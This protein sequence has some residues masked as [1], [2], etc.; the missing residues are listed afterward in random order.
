MQNI[1]VESLYLP[2]VESITQRIGIAEDAIVQVET[3]PSN[4]LN[5]VGCE[6]AVL[7]LRMICE[8]ILLGST[9]AHLHEAGI[10]ISDS[11]WRPKDAFFELS[12][13]SEHPLPIPVEVQIDRFGPG[14]HHLVPKSQPIPFAALSKIY[15]ICGDL[16][17]APSVR[18]IRGNRLPEFDVAQ[19]SSWLKGFREI[20]MA[21]ALMLPEREIVMFCI[22]SGAT[23]E[24]PEA[25][26]LDAK[27][28]STMEISSYPPFSIF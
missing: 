3:N 25:F 6:V 13:I 11:K 18:Q 22:W 21:H 28:P 10:D 9:A 15:G 20:V 14:R 1:A 26:R 27:G 19:I 12:K 16:L 8:L 23:D 4:P 2:V 7:Q 24:I 17:H 5:F